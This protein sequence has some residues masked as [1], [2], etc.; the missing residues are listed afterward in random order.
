MAVKSISVLSN[1]PAISLKAY[2]AIQDTQSAVPGDHVAAIPARAKMALAAAEI[3]TR[4]ISPAL[5]AG[6]SPSIQG[7]DNFDASLGTLSGTLVAQQT[8]EFFGANTPA[9]EAVASDVSSEAGR[10]GETITIRYAQA[11]DVQ[12]YDPVNGWSDA[13]LKTVDIPVVL[14][15]HIGVPITFG[16]NT[17]GA[18]LRRLFDEFAPAAAFSLAKKLTDMLYAQITPANF[19]TVAIASALPAFGRSSIIDAGTSLTNAGAPMGPKNRTVLLNAAYWGQLNKDP[20]ILTVANVEP[21]EGI[22]PGVLPDV[23]QSKV[24]AAPNLPAANSLFGFAFSKSG[25]AIATRLSGDIMKAIPGAAYG[26][27]QVI[28]DLR[29][30]ISCRVINFVNHNRGTATSLIS[31]MCGAG[32]GRPDAGQR[33]TTL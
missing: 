14:S 2:L 16:Q 3:F 22:G 13:V 30:G 32:P 5:R 9:L 11:P 28:T 4:E 8:L 27:Q 33:L 7:S 12:D 10:F 31:L 26:S 20:G 19:P 15:R 1:D 24:I 25:L 21:S 17:V 6:W 23:G 18:T 29:T